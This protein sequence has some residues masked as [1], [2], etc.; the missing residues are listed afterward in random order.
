MSF[1]SLVASYISQGS[2]IDEMWNMFLAVHF[3]FVGAIFFTE[4]SSS[5]EFQFSE[6]ILIVIAY[7]AFAFINFRA[8]WDAYVFIHNIVADIK[9]IPVDI[10][11]KSNI[12]S[13]FKALSVTNPLITISVAH[14][15]GVSIIFYW[16]F[17][18]KSQK[19]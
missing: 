1:D 12:L 19:S 10:A 7:G 13:Y 15:I 18:R 11:G 9:A 8:K 4:K 2:I 17:L 6:K 14:I 16:L 3:A 5:H